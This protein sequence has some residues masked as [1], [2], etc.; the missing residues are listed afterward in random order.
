MKQIFKDHIK[1]HINIAVGI[2]NG[3]WYVQTTDTG[4]ETYYAEKIDDGLNSKE[5][6]LAIANHY[7]KQYDLNV[8]VW[9]KICQPDQHNK[10]YIMVEV[11]GLIVEDIRVYET[12]EEAER[13]FKDY[14]GIDYAD[15]YKYENE[16]MGWEYSQTKIFE[17]TI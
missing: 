14:T 2:E 3:K 15:S 1:D 7:A 16:I 13:A 10:R 9:D 17:V 5:E 11:F 6:A 12:R 8:I 4:I